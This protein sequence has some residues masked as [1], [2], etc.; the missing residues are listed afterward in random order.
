[1]KKTNIVKW[2]GIGIVGLAIIMGFVVSSLTQDY[3]DYK[4]ATNAQLASLNESGTMT[5]QVDNAVE[6]YQAVSEAVANNQVPTIHISAPIDFDAKAYDDYN[7]L[8]CTVRG[9]SNS[10]GT[11]VMSDRSDTF[12]FLQI[13]DN[14]DLDLYYQYC[15]Y[16]KGVYEF[17]TLYNQSLYNIY[18]QAEVEASYGKYLSY[19]LTSDIGVEHRSNNYYRI[20]ELL[21]QVVLCGGQ[22]EVIY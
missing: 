18:L 2:L 12:R 13:P 14:G 15:S 1:M 4:T 3:R 11:P 7:L 5:V 10:T 17:A 20:S 19:G 16:G 21:D 8:S 22:L 9:I 6:L